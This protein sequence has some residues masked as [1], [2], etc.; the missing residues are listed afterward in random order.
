MSRSCQRCCLVTVEV[1]CWEEAPKK[2]VE[3]KRRQVS[4][5]ERDKSEMKLLKKW[6][7]ASKRRQQKEDQME[8]QWAEDEILEEILERRRRRLG[9]RCLNW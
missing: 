7:R 1:G 6:L 5:A 4:N 8:V 3:K 9:K 2:Q